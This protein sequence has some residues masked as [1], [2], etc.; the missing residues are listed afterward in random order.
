[1][2][3]NTGGKRNVA[4]APSYGGLPILQP[5]PV[6]RH[7]HVYCH[8]VKNGG[9]EQQCSSSP[10]LC[11]EAEVVAVLLVDVRVCGLVRHGVNYDLCA[12]ESAEAP[13]VRRCR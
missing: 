5:S 4:P 11:G 7:S 3:P 1:M 9:R 8:T 2:C 10:W 12:A 6:S 13:G